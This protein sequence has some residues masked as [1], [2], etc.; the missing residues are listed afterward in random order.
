[1]QKV[2]IAGAKR[3]PIGSFLG[4]LKDVSAADLGKTAIQG[5]LNQSG[6]DP[7]DIDEVS[8]GNVLSAGQGQ[9]VSRQASI[10]A[11][12]P[13]TTPAYGTNMVCG[14]G[15]KTVMNAFIGIRAGEY[16]VVVAGG[17]ESM[18]QAPY[19]IPNRTRMGIKMGNFQTIDHMVHD[20]LTDAFEGYHMGVTAENI[21]EQYGISREDQDVFAFDSQKKSIEAL[22]NGL[23][24]EEVVSVEYTT[25]RKEQVI[26]DTDEYPNRKANLE[27]MSSLRPAFKK[28]G[29]VTAGNA[30]GL[31]DGASAT[32]IVGEDYL[33]EKSVQPLAEIVAIG[34]SG[35][36]PSIMGIGPV[37]AIQQALKKSELSFEDIDVFE[38]NEA[39][40]SQSLAVVHELS[41]TFKVDEQ[42]LKAKTN[43]SG[44][45]ISLG[46]PIGASGNRILVTLLYTLK[47]KG[48]KYGIAS[49]CIGGGMGAAV[50]IRNTDID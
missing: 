6:V 9:G 41:E 14:S 34:Q 44:G 33:Q 12:I 47:R 23:F 18:S 13:E 43:M 39:F 30:S 2:Y 48:L 50:I 24:K 16:N 38:L 20:G 42:A 3:T 8:L 4:A 10:K 27:K 22:D 31:N 32:L 37:P 40:A 35:V 15:L 5:V 19:L 17:T 45:A 25:R 1:M 21:A 28:E 29:T 36:N 46:H 49:L 7:T 11:G 26:V